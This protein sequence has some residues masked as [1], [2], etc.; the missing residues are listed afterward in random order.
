MPAKIGV[1]A[2]LTLEITEADT[3]IAHR[4][5]SVAVLATP[6]VVALV[7]EASCVA[8]AGQLEAGETSVGM[9]IQLDHLAPVKIG[10]CI[11]AVATLER[12]EG[13]R[14]IFAVSVSDQAGLVAAG[15]LTRAIVDVE[16]FLDKAR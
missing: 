16:T 11:R 5:G 6:R 10:S 15:K 3:A 7:E 8:L 2:E 1:S 4:S 12:Q 9:R 14:L 13:R